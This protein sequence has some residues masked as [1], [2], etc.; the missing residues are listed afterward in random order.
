MKYNLIRN[1]SL[2][3]LTTSGTGNKSLTWLE[4]DKITDGNLTTSG[5]VIGAADNLHLEA[6]LSNRIKVDGIRLYADDLTKSANIKF[7]YKDQESDSYSI[8]LTNVGASYYYT[9]I[10]SPSAPQYVKVTISGI[11]ITLYEFQIFNDD[12]IVAYGT[13]GSMTTKYLE[14]A[15]IGEES[16]AEAIPIYN[17]SSN[18]M[19]ADAYVCIDYTGNV[20]DNYLKIAGT[21][22]GTYYELSDGGILDTNITSTGYKWDMGIYDGTQTDNH[23]VE[24]PTVVASGFGTYTTPVIKLINKYHTSYFTSD[25]TTTSGLSSISYDENMYNGTIRVRSSDTAPLTIDEVYWYEI[26]LSNPPN[27]RYQY[28][29]KRI[30]YDGTENLFWKY[31]DYLP[32]TRA[33]EPSCTAINRRNGALAGFRNVGDNGGRIHILRSNGS[34]FDSERF[35]TDETDYYVHMRFDKSGGVWAGWKHTMDDHRMAHVGPDASTLYNYSA[36][37]EFFYD[38][39]VEE[40]GN[41]VWYTDPNGDMVYNLDTNGNVVTTLNAIVTPRAICSTSD[42]GCWVFD[43]DDQYARRYN[44]VGELQQSVDMGTDVIKMASDFE[45]GFWFIHEN[46]YYVSHM[47]SN[48]II[49]VD[50]VNIGWEIQYIDGGYNGCLVY[51]RAT[52]TAKYV[53]KASSSVIRSFTAQNT[54]YPGIPVLFS[55]RYDDF[56]TYQGDRI[57]MPLNYDPVWGTGGSLDWKEVRLN[58]YYLPKHQYHQVEYTLRTAG[59]ENPKLNKVILAPAVKVEDIQAQSYKN[60]YIKTEIPSDADIIDYETKLRTWWGINS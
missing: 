42:S 34:F 52:Y 59:V 4:L 8:I 54:S 27:G 43:E 16:N 22:N 35:G 41:G 31:H 13:D 9:T 6:N 14:D 46:G 28:F 18:V 48:G 30:I 51:S 38:F 53:D 23:S 55:Y 32:V 19:A 3:A 12:Y 57:T 11:D 56:I 49:D 24:L 60:V 58:G 20:A 39:D 33:D 17:N 36:A 25:V 10:T 1:G 29:S 26:R 44:S 5:V 2:Q 47:N 21:A 37:G 50:S 40:D 45:D 15:P 7:Y